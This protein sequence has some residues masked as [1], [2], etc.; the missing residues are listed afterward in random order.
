MAGSANI[1]RRYAM[2]E[3]V[4]G[5]ADRMFAEGR[6]EYANPS[7]LLRAAAMLLVHIGLNEHA[8]RL[9]RTLDICLAEGAEIQTT[10]YR[11]G[12]TCREFGDYLMETLKRT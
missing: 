12:A 8:A 7:S 4:H 9:E 6:A 10:G 2:F 5:S 1:G 3:A 11:N